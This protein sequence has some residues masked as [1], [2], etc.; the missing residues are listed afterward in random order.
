M[1]LYLLMEEHIVGAVTYF[2]SLVTVLELEVGHEWSVILTM[3][4]ALTL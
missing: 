4:E 3:V 2:T 1:Q